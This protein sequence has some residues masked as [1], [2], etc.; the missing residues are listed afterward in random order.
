MMQ[1]KTQ[2]VA[3]EVDVSVTEQE[4]ALYADIAEQALEQMRGWSRTRS[5]KLKRPLRPTLYWV[6]R[7]NMDVENTA[8][9]LVTCNKYQARAI[10]GDYDWAPEQ[11]AH[12]G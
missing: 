5:G 9:L 3:I 8:S 6:M 7:R 12:A 1:K 4:P 2:T 10:T 11:A